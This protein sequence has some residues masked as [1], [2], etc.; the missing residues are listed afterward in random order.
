M[1]D[2]IPVTERGRELKKLMAIIMLTSIVSGK[3][4]DVNN[5][6]NVMKGS[7]V[8]AGFFCLLFK[9][10]K[11]VLMDFTSAKARVAN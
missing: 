7:T 1:V 8:R 10:I 2:V 4:I 6:A 9:Y 5:Y 11:Y 3:D